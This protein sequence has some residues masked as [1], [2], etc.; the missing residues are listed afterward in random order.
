MIVALSFSNVVVSR[1]EEMA[2]RRSI[3]PS[4]STQEGAEGGA[5][6]SMQR[7]RLTTCMIRRGDKEQSNGY[8]TLLLV[9][10]KRKRKGLDILL[11][12]IELFI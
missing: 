10:W 12:F 11:I 1:I 3:A 2:E 6:V 8:I 4:T 7:S 9:S 5:L